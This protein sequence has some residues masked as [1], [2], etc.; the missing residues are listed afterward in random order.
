MTPTSPLPSLVAIHVE[1]RDPMRGSVEGGLGRREGFVG[2]LALLAALERVF[3]E[4]TGALPSREPLQPAHN[5]TTDQTWS[6]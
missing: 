4:S 5:R 1:S 2:W 3:A 6:Y